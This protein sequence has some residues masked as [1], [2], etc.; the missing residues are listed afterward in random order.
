M[1]ESN[2]VMKVIINDNQYDNDN[3]EKNGVILM[4]RVII[5]Q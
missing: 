1:S 3:D 2:E 5:R 4:R